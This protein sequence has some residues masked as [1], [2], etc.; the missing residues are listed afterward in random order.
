VLLERQAEAEDVW[1]GKRDCNVAKLVQA[2]RGVLVLAAL[3]YNYLL[4]RIAGD[5]RAAS[6]SGRLAN[7]PK[8]G[9][10]AKHRR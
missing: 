4:K 6:A 9:A 1:V 7:W 8:L 10:S 5:M 3:R 2:V